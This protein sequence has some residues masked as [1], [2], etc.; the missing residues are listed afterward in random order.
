MAIDTEL[1]E[2]LV[3]PE[4]RQGIRV[5]DAGTLATL[6][7]AIAAGRVRNRAG[8]VVR[9]GV[10]EALV[11]EDGRLLYLVKEGIPVMLCGQ[12]VVLPLK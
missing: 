1:L 12:A 11:R 10:E 3:C 7:A 2:I 8:E 9:E 6:N 5:A 4:T